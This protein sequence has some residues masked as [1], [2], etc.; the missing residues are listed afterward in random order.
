MKPINFKESNAVIGGQVPVNRT[1]GM[2]LSRWLMTWSERVSI[3]FHGKIWLAVKGDYMPPVLLS[4]DQSFYIEPNPDTWTQADDER[5]T[6]AMSDHSMGPV[7]E[8]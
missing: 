4:G 5:L 8:K 2:V 1:H 3:L 6:H 7:E